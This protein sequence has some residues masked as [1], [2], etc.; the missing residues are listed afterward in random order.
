[1]Q[2]PVMHSPAI[3]GYLASVAPAHHMTSSC[4]IRETEYHQFVMVPTMAVDVPEGLSH[5]HYIH[6]EG[7]TFTLTLNP[8]INDIC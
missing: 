3:K 5:S 2:I 8:N 4:I 1:M 7:L 6:S